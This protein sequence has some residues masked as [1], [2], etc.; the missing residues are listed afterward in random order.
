ML[1]KNW[2]MQSGSW[3]T[4][5]REFA[6]KSQDAEKDIADGEQKLLDAQE[7]LDDLEVPEWYVLD[8]NTLETYVEYGQNAD[9]IGAIG[10]VF[11]VI[12]FL[13][14]ALVSDRP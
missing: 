2:P 3:R 13:V 8:R 10:K 12:F 9:R 6:E 4:D 14:A 5:S 7:A 1:K 11:P